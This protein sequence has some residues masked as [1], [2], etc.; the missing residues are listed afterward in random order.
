M[1]FYDLDSMSKDR[2]KDFLEWYEIHK[3]DTFDFQK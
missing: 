2:R 1:K 3:N